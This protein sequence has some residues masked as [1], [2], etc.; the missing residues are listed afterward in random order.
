[1]RIEKTEQGKTKNGLRYYLF[2]RTGFGEQMAAVL[3]QRGANHLFWKGRDGEKICFPQG[4]AHFIEHKLFQQ[5]WGDAFARF[6]QNG[7][8]ANAF[9]DGDRTVYYFTCS[10]KFTENL[11]LLL[12]FVQKPYFTKEDTEREKDIIVSEITMYEDDPMWVGYYQMLEC[13]YGKHPIRNRIAGTAE[14][15][16]EITEETLQ[17][18]Y[19]CYYTTDEMALICAGDIPLGE[20]R[21]IAE[22]VARRE[23]D[24]RLY[25]PT[26]DAEIAEKYRACERRLSVPQFQIGCKLP[27]LPKQDWLK[28][29]M[30]AG[31]CMELLAGESS[32]FFQKAYEWEWLDE[33][34][35][36]AFFC[37]EGYAFA[38]FSGSGIASGGNSGF[39]GKGAGAPATRRL[40][41]GGFS[42]YPQK[43][44]GAAPAAAGYTA[45]ALLWTACVGADGCNGNRPFD[46]HQDRAAGGSG[47]NAEGRLF[48]RKYGA[49]GC[50]IKRMPSIRLS[51]GHFL[52]VPQRRREFFGRENRKV[53]SKRWLL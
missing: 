38:A 4:T 44:L 35:G 41:A 16:A 51:G 36:S 19:A 24:A 22:R 10:D 11:R 13:M 6:T 9:T 5:E 50:E 27:P 31:F 53:D 23:T 1:M 25:F 37:G 29:R 15:V 47:K 8:S 42:A 12:D 34:L 3:V 30:A 49:F 46:L 7:A 28:K 48:K 26:E 21:R 17:R 45:E 32:V 18:A 39:S 14:T 43:A 20:V 40:F 33:A 2:P 52:L